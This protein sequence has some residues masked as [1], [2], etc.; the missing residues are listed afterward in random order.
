MRI[1]PFAVVA[2]HEIVANSKRLLRR[3]V[4][5]EDILYAV[6]G[7]E[8]SGRIAHQP[9]DGAFARNCRKRYALFRAHDFTVN[10]LVDA[11]QVVLELTD[12]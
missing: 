9:F 4:L 2:L 6:A 3:Q 1:I 10:K 11:A 7:V 12:A 5:V 8:V